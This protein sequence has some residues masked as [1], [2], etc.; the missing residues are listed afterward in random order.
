MLTLSVAG[1]LITVLLFLLRPITQ[2]VFNQT[3]RYRMC[4][5]AVMFFLLPVGAA[6]NSLYDAL[7]HQSAQP[8]RPQ[9]AVTAVLDTIAP[10]PITGNA[11]IDTSAQ[12]STLT[13]GMDKG[14][15]LNILPFLPYIW[16]T[17]AVLSVCTNGLRYIRFRRR[18]IRTCL[19][20][21]DEKIYSL[22][23]AGKTT[24]GVSGKILLLTSD[25]VKTPML[26]GIFRTLLVLPEVE[27]N[28]RELSTIF[29]HELIH[30]QRRDLWVKT[31]MLLIGAIHWFNPVIYLL[32]K[33][34]ETSCE[35]SCDEQVVRDMS[36]EDR[37]FYGETILNMLGRVA[38]K[39]ACVYAT[40][41]ETKKGI[42]RRLTL[43]LRFKEM[44]KKTA[45]ISVV[46]AML[47]TLAGCIG[48]ASVSDTAGTSPAAGADVNNETASDTEWVWPVEGCHNIFWAFGTRYHP[49][50]KV[51]VFN[52]NIQITGKGIAGAAVYAAL[53]G[54]V[55]EVSFDDERGNYI[56][57][58]HGNGI[59]TFYLHLDET[60]VSAGDPVSAGDT[61]GTAGS[62]G[63]ATAPFLAFGVYLNG[64]AVDPLNYLKS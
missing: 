58:D 56:M 57:I 18:L 41:A 59:E 6:G 52:D 5:L 13:P 17:G 25:T 37:H 50:K 55:S 27:V 44:S 61:I 15:S 43:M 26:T 12:T 63:D 19:P 11:V 51:K 16:L 29:K 8:D 46:I 9:A 32:A 24:Q 33:E 7:L 36:L 45:A 10:L 64:I 31:L 49:I 60:L 34:A 35:L 42:E 1:S 54:T 48:A 4:I 23:E 3:W 53:A 28:E 21:E 39:Q 40:L 14:I 20:V 62:T 38:E 2:R 30:Y 47:C 22:L